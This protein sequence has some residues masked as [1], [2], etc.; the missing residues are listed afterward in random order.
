MNTKQRLFGGTQ[1]GRTA[2]V[3][4]AIMALA[5]AGCASTPEPE[6]G[7]VEV[8]Q[9]RVAHIGTGTATLPLFIGMDR[10]YFEEEGIE[11]VTD[12]FG[13][14]PYPQAAAGEIDIVSGDHAAAVQATVGGL[15]LVFLGETSRMIRGNHQ[16]V[17]PADSNFQTIDDLRGA[18]IGV[19]NLVGSAR[20]ALDAMLAE[21]GLTD[22][23]VEIS[24]VA[25]DALG[26]ALE[27][28]NID[29][30]HLPGAFLDAAKQASDLT[31][32]ADFA[33]LKGLD[34]LAQAGYYVPASAYDRN[35]E[36]YERFYRAYTRAAQDGIDD[37]DLLAEYLVKLA[38]TDPGVLERMPLPSQ[39]VDSSP[40]KLQELVDMMHKSGLIEVKV[41]VGDG[42]LRVADFYN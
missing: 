9:L 4:A 26:P 3:G 8:T 31:V 28:G 13:T 7:E 41:K 30:A 27:L 11:V 21:A 14:A 2:L 10:G 17:T 23:D 34:G 22:D 36:A 6:A 19:S 18:R 42:N 32:V 12:S 25:L 24:K 20:F 39:V 15:G 16:F 38:K 1:R 29:V 35:P 40:K 5:L 37:P 33:D